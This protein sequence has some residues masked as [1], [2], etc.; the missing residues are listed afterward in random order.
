MKS[1]KKK[2]INWWG[3]GGGN[4]GIHQDEKVTKKRVY[5]M[6][7]EQDCESL[8]CVHIEEQVPIFHPSFHTLFCFI[9]ILSPTPA[10]FRK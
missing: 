7:S 4:G 6:W 2:V 10:V 8:V 5:Y 3:K 1:I 9:N